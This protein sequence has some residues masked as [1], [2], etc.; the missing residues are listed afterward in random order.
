MVDPLIPD[1]INDTV[2]NFAADM[3]LKLVANMHKGGWADSHLSF[4]MSRLLQ[5]TGELV[6]AMMS[7]DHNWTAAEA[8][9]VAN[10]AMMIHNKSKPPQDDRPHFCQG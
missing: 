2:D 4:L 6:E 3:K 7:G 1:E 5:E 8:V 9:D 10:F